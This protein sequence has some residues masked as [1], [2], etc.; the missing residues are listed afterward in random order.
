MLANVDAVGVRRDRDRQVQAIVLSDL[1][2]DSTVVL[3]PSH[4]VA[5]A[6]APRENQ[7][8]VLLTSGAKVTCLVPHDADDGPAVYAELVDLLYQVL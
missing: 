5:L 4:I 2:R 1:D 3:V 6:E 8:E 7:V